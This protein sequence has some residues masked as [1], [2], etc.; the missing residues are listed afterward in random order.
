MSDLDYQKENI[1]NEEEYYSYSEDESIDEDIRVI[2]PDKIQIKTSSVR[3][4]YD[5]YLKCNKTIL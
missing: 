2:T 4:V 5:N 3:S 1:E